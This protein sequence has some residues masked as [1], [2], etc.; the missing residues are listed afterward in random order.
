MHTFLQFVFNADGLREN[1]REAWMELYDYQYLDDKV[2]GGIEKNL[3]NVSEILRIVE[4]KAT[5]KVQSTLSQQGGS[6]HGGASQS[7]FSETQSEKTTQSKGG[8]MSAMSGTMMEGDINT[9]RVTEPIPFNLT[10]PKPKVIPQ[11]E[12]LVREV[13][14]NPMPKHI[15]KKSV[16]D[17]EKEKEE[18]RK[19]KTEAI[20]RE[21]E[22]NKAKRFELATEKLPSNTKFD[23]AKAKLEEQLQGELRFEGTKPRKAPNFEKMEAP[24]KLTAAA[25]KREALAL[26]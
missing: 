8:R 9:K 16:I 18:R 23:Q 7:N 22:E 2:I 13:K 19:A 26:K 20:R 15:F 14:A 3:P 6:T 12:A 5:G 17:I 24:V 4:R 1:V 10:K 21:Y 25:V 11:P